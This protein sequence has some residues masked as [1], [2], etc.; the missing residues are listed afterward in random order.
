MDVSRWND[1]AADAAD[2]PALLDGI[3]GAVLDIGCG[4]GRM[5]RATH[6]SGTPPHSASTRVRAFGSRGPVW[7]GANR[8]V[9]ERLP[10]EG[11]WELTALLVDGNIRV[12]AEIPLPC[13]NAALELIAADGVIVVEVHAEPLRIT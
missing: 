13:S 8:S 3:N 5:V 4:P 10:N 7:R 9:F 6:A 11:L 1:F 12:S 2:L